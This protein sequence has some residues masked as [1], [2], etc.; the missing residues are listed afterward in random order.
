MFELSEF[1]G[2]LVPLR[3]IEKMFNPMK[4]WLNVG[5]QVHSSQNWPETKWKIM[6]MLNEIEIYFKTS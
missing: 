6:V 1:C 2:W 4:F 5:N 3:E